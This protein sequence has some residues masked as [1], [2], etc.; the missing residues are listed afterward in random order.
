MLPDLPPLLSHQQAA[1]A[2][3]LT[4][5][6]IGKLLAE[7]RLVGNGHSIRTTSL[8]CYIDYQQRRLIEPPPKH[9]TVITWPGPTS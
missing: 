2:L 5:P 6:E 8:R 4:V 1:E 3:H 9:V 7:G